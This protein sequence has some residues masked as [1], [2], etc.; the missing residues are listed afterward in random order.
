MLIDISG[1]G[2]SCH[3]PPEAICVL[4]KAAAVLQEYEA[5]AIFEH[6]REQLFAETGNPWETLTALAEKAGLHRYT[7]HQLF[8]IFCTE[9]THARYRA[10]GH[11]ES[12]YW[13]SMKDLKHKMEETHQVYGV[14]GV[15]CGPWLSLFIRMRCFCLGRLQFEIVPSEFHYELD[16]HVLQRGDPVVNIHIP[17]FGRLGYEDVLVSYSRAAKFFAHLY[18]DGS[19]WFQC[20]TWILY[21]PVNALLPNGNMKRFSKDF[22]IV[23]AFIDPN[24]DDRYRVFMLPGT[25]PIAD[26]PENN[27]LQRDLKAWLLAGN[28]M[29]VAY[30]FFLWKDGHIVPRS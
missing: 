12:L 10:A 11:P 6:C 5:E 17:S 19:V 7:V 26:Y 20:E 13:D 4:Q 15:Y 1:F 22:D 30:G 8:L 16:G 24:Q 21:P 25:V 18:P 2:H 3:F 29:G 14:W 23:H 27:A 28:T 9:E